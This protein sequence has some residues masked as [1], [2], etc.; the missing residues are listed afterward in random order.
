VN[1][2][3]LV[4]PCLFTATLLIFT[5]VIKGLLF[6]KNNHTIFEYFISL[7]SGYGF[8]VNENIKGFGA[9]WFLTALF[10]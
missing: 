1:I 10:C 8:A 7:I 5:D 6:G 3:R 4:A 9:L 2:N